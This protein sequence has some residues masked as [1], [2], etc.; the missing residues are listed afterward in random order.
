M[1]MARQAILGSLNFRAKKQ[2]LRPKLRNTRLAE[3]AKQADVV[4]KAEDA[5]A[6]FR[7]LQC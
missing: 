4:A 2:K 1:G 7:A 5:I 3:E 6:N